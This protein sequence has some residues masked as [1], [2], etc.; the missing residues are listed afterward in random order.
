MTDNA[1]P[2]AR[3][4]LVRFIRSADGAGA[5]LLFLIAA[6]IAL[7]AHDLPLGRM[8]RPGPAILPA[9]LA[10]VLALSALRLSLK[11]LLTPN[12]VAIEAPHSLSF[13]MLLPAF[14]AFALMADVAGLALSSLVLLLVA[15][16]AVPGANASAKRAWRFGLYAVLLSAF[17]VLLFAEL[18][19]L[20]IAILPEGW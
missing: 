9:V 12:P 14:L 1:A 17:C 18:L 5:I 16:T 3:H 10:C 13:L 20:P 4:V 7:A 8:R 15:G 6:F 2:A 19:G 11:A